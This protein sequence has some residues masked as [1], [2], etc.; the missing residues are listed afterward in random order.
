MRG[1]A[2]LSRRSRS[3]IAPTP[4]RTGSTHRQAEL[5]LGAAQVVARRAG[6]ERGGIDADPD[7]A[8]RRVGQLRRL[9]IAL[10]AQPQVGQLVVRQAAHMR[11]GRLVAHDQRVGLGAVDQPQRDPGI[12]GV[13]QRALALDQV[14]MVGVVGRAQ[15]FDRARH[16]IGDDR[17]DRDAVAGDEDAGLAGGAEIGLEPARPH[18]LFERQR[19]EHLADRA[20]GADRQ[21]PLARA[22]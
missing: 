11:A 16:E 10:D 18:L 1:H 17:V 20:I 14:P 3:T 2:A 15:P 13:E 9:D 5:V 21:Q 6:V 7:A 4:V 19:G 12:G 22:A 8:R